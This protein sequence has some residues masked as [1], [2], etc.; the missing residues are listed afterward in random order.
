MPSAKRRVSGRRSRA[1]SGSTPTVRISR[2]DS[3]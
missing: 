1:L 2:S 3:V